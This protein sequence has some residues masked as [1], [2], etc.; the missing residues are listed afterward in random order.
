[1]SEKIANIVFDQF[2]RPS[3][4]LEDRLEKLETKAARGLEALNATGEIG[5]DARVDIAML[6]AVQ[7]CR[8]PER[9]A[10]RLDLG[11]YLAIAIGDV[12][13]YQD[14][15]ALN[16][17]L[18]TN[19]MLPGASLTEEE[20]VLLRQSSQDNLVSQ[21]DIILNSYG[22][23]NFFNPGLIIDAAPQVCLHLL[24]L[25]WNLLFSPTPAFI[26]SDRPV[27][28][29]IYYGFSVGLT[30][31]YGL[32]LSKATREVTDDVICARQAEEV[33][34]QEINNEVKSRAHEWI[35]GPGEWVHKFSV[36]S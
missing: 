28:T 1:M 29:S 26:L 16:R 27:P 15:N 7:A 20:F 33:K 4:Q 25:E 14:A 32:V 3:D 6:L 30:A 35:C 22:Y 24:A 36:R 19:G 18:R 13:A 10:D 34:I 11:K 21:L 17:A 9:F 2:F 8:Y 12:Y 31:S 23:E 5:G